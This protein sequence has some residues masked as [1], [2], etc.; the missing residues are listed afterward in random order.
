MHVRAADVPE[1][2]ELQV[3][4]LWSAHSL[5][6]PQ[7][8]RH[9]FMIGDLRAGYGLARHLQVAAALPVR[10]WFVSRSPT[11]RIGA[12]NHAGFG[13]L[14]TSAKLQLP[15][16]WRALRLGALARVSSPT[17][18]ARSGFTTG[19]TDVEAGGLLTLDLTRLQR[20]V[21]TRLHLNV[22]YRWNHNEAQGFGL[23][24]LDSITRGGFWPP[25]YPAVPPG[26]PARYNDQVLLRLGAEFSTRIA[27]LFTEFTWDRFPYVPGLGWRQSPVQL[28]EGA[29]IRFRN[30]LDL[31]G[32]VDLSLQR[33][34]APASMPRLPD[35]RF[36]L[37]LTWSTALSLGD[38]DHD[39]ITDKRDECPDAAEDLDGHADADGC[40][41]PDN[42]GD[43]ILDAADR[44]PDLAED[45]DGFEDADGRPDMDND[46]DGIP[47]ARDACPNQAE[48]YDGV[49]DV[50]GCP[51]ASHS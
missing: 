12:A 11:S 50:D 36:T 49:E 23:A 1:R 8:S 40:P 25:A 29:L 35:W 16:P 20:F 21:P 43:G 28:T 27:A 13:D 2:G 6:D 44:A 30:G 47:D 41:D 24:P 22:L 14:A 33:H 3:G 46:G 31:V 26:S 15:L 42:D 48:D 38:R 7:D 4:S 10:A 17:G 51:E 18:S 32:A 34:D 5:V 19:T 37:G 45:F 9:Y 39:G